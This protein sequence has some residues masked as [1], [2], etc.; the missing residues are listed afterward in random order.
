MHNWLKSYLTNRIQYTSFQKV[1]SSKERLI[2]GVPQG[3]ILGPLMFI[4]YVND[5][6]RALKDLYCIIFADDTNVFIK[7]TNY[8]ILIDRLNKDLYNIS[9]WLKSNKLSLN[10]KKLITCYFIDRGLKM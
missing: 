5:L 2:C 6:H 3:S 1:N 7:H 4:L 10:V 9:E 8:E